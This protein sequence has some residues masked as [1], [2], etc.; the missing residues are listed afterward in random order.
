MFSTVVMFGMPTAR[1]PLRP[2]VAAVGLKVAVSK[3]AIYQGS[4]YV[5]DLEHDRERN[6]LLFAGLDGRVGYLDLDSGNS[7]TLLEVSDRPA[8]QRLALSGDLATLSEEPIVAAAVDQSLTG[9]AQRRAAICPLAVGHVF[10][11]PLR[12]LGPPWCIWFGTPLKR[13]VKQVVDRQD[14]QRKSCLTS[15]GLQ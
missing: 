1:C 9:F 5:Y 7:G 13:I 11:D 3:G 14:A 2:S 15:K 4:S 8:I 12:C 6:R 10:I